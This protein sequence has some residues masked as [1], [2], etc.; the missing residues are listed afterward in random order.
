EGIAYI[1]YWYAQN[2]MALQRYAEAEKSLRKSL[3]IYRGISRD[4]WHTWIVQ[5][6]LGDLLI[7]SKQHREA[8]QKL[9]EN[10]HYLKEYLGIESNYTQ[11]SISLLSQLYDA[12]N[13]PLTAAH[14][15]KM[16][17]KQD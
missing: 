12:W 9:L 8:E 7:R 3:A 10:Y 17:V 1:Y 11:T 15:R 4:H 16:L 5:N 13:K 2:L 14:Y 6:I